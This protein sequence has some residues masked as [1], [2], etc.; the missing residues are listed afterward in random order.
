MNIIDKI[1]EI[2]LDWVSVFRNLNKKRDC[3]LFLHKRN[4]T[5][6]QF[7][8]RIF[9]V[10]DDAGVNFITECIKDTF[11]CYVKDKSIKSRYKPSN[12][13]I[14]QIWYNN[15]FKFEFIKPAHYQHL[16]YSCELAEK[17]DI[18]I[19]LDSIFVHSLTKI[20]NFHD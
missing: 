18:S 14:E 9:I 3:E 5:I 1:G 8:S 7:N 15:L 13:Y 19:G 6:V 2:F 17:Y 4:L 11:S 20:Q 16:I 12:P 10:L